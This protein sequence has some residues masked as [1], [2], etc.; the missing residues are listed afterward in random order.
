MDVLSP[1]QRVRCMAAV[2]SINTYPELQVRRIVHR[3]GYRYRLH[4]RELPGRPDLVFPSRRKVIFV[5]GCFWHRHNCPAGRS[6]PATRQEFWLK[7]LSRNRERDREQRTALKKM[8][9][10]VMIIWECTL[11]RRGPD[12]VVSRPEKR[13]VG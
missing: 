9:W 5:H 1:E 3:L 8:G 11:D 4:V 12:S 6:F 2:R 10:E 7:K 13:R